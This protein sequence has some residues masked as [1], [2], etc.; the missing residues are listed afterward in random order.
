MLQAASKDWQLTQRE[1]SW[2]LPP[3]QTV[4]EEEK[5]QARALGKAEGMVLGKTKDTSGWEQIAAARSLS[6]KRPRT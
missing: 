6:R 1:G 2:E 4:V 5:T 3:A